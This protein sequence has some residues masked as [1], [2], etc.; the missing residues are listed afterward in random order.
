MDTFKEIVLALFLV[1][2]P[3]F[4]A[5]L[6]KGNAKLARIIFAFFVAGITGV[7]AFLYETYLILIATAIFAFFGIYGIIKDNETD[8]WNR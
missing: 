3:V 7:A 8:I 1:V 5:L 6:V 4:L 2:I